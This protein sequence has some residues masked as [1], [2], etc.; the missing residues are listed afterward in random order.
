MIGPTE[1]NIPVKE[2]VKLL[3]NKDLGSEMSKTW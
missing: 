1:E 3:T 2:F